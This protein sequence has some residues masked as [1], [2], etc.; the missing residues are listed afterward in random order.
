MGQTEQHKLERLQVPEIGEILDGRYRVQGVIATGGMGVIL[1]AEQLPM[2]R[3][4]ALKLL[5]P[6]IAVA[7]PNL[8]ERFAREVRL[9]KQLNHPNTIRLYD[10]GKSEQGLVYVAMEMLDGM[11]LKRRIAREGVM[12]V[13]AALEITRQ[14][15]D[16]LAEAHARGFIHRDLKPS[17]V[18]IV[19]NRR[20]EDLVKL[21]DFG[22]AKSLSDSAD[23][24]GSGSICGT[25]SYVAPEYL[26][27]E[28]PGK[29]ADIY[30]VGLI[31][32]EMLTGRQ[33]FKGEAPVQTMMMHLKLDPDI[34]DEIAQTPL[35]E[36]IER[37][38]A[39]DPNA[40]YQDAEEMYAA[41]CAVM[42]QVPADLKVHR[43]SLAA[44]PDATEAVDEELDSA[45]RE[46][47]SVDTIVP[48]IPSGL[49]SSDELPQAQSTPS[50]VERAVSSDIFRRELERQRF[51]EAR[52]AEASSQRASADSS[53]GPRAMAH[54][55]GTPVAG[56]IVAG[57]IGSY[58]RWAAATIA[59][60]A[61]VGVGVFW[62]L[63]P[64]DAPEFVT[65]VSSPSADDPGARAS[66]SSE[67]P[68]EDVA[69]S[70]SDEKEQAEARGISFDLDTDPVGATVYVGEREVGHTP[71]THK[72]IEEKL[73]QTVR[74]ELEGYAPKQ[75]E[76]T[77]TSSPI[78]V[79]ILEEQESQAV[80]PARRASAEPPET[81]PTKAEGQ[82]DTAPDSPEG[83]EA[84]A[85]RL[86]DE[87]IEQVM[88]QYLR[89]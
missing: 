53:A 61:L 56:K 33:V 89:D 64:G 54:G 39:K 44:L 82:T 51:E 35:A 41:V 18:F 78:V 70:V 65:P 74:F 30:A 72:V 58:V 47:A 24:T 57:K 45:E 34:P 85:E 3:S 71:T 76:L 23:L 42:R 36:V 69:G 49:D 88:D 62:A 19:K 5:H 17:N 80:E 59:L 28:R 27:Q 84:T 2:E 22:I 15:L 6:H 11:D 50:W 32:L 87:R 40:R 77:R 26:M 10:F 4:V 21:L 14:M 79:E 1:R 12:S 37:A 48:E 38:T 68:L 75:V 67:A 63:D 60:A 52:R 43:P 81:S 25:P 31:L 8:V 86:S 66:T 83:K 29:P 55:G 16:G 46:R 13:G 73:P 7:D 20:G 9:A